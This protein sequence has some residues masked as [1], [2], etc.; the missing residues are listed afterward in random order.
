MNKNLIFR[1][2]S[3]L[4]KNQS[5]ITNINTL[6]KVLSKNFE[7]MT[8]DELIVTLNKFQEFESKDPNSKIKLY[9][10]L[11]Y[12]LYDEKKLG[13]NTF[14]KTIMRSMLT[15]QMYDKTYWDYYKKIILRNNL[16]FSSQENYI[17]YLKIY[18]IVNYEDAEL[19][20]LFEE[21]IIESSRSF[22]LEQ[23]QSII[24]CFANCKKGTKNF[25]QILFQNFNLKNQNHPEFIL[26]FSISLCGYLQSKIIDQIDPTLVEEFCKYLNFSIEFLH[27]DLKEGTSLEKIDIV[28]SLFPHFHKSYYVDQIQV[29]FPHVI[30]SSLF[31]GFIENLE[32]IL[33]NYLDKHINKLEDEDFEQ[34]SK[35]L[36]YSCD[37][38]I[39]FLKLKPAIF[40]TI[41]TDDISAV[42][43]YNDLFNFL[44]YFYINNIKEEKLKAVLNSDVIWERFIDEMHLMPFEQLMTLTK[45]MKYYNVKYFRIW[46]FL[47][48]FFRRHI[49]NGIEDFTIL[50]DVV[51]VKDSRL[52]LSRVEEVIKIF[53]DETSKF[54]YEE[55]V[56]I[57]FIIYLRN[58]KDDLIIKISHE[59]K[60][61]A[62]KH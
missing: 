31:K 6:N 15:V 9:D 40:A 54:K 61:T 42:K 50:N 27:K 24:L 26:N 7:K 60:N 22:Q 5:K 49:K 59:N 38:K 57:H 11:D 47:Q 36:K 46:V 35:F 8:K 39:A 4:A 44:N 18:S 33:K 3:I 2:F 21:Y 1:K 10:L 53:D 25:W 52:L 55:F 34:I 62:P 17:D 23:I 20:Q 43:N 13:D 48:N 51:Y 58:V 16:L 30:N 29:R 37:N 19:W 45:F 14:L 12:I 32:N 41:F 56:L 28:Y